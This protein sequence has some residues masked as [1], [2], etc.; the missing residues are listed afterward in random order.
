MNFRHFLVFLLACL[1]PPASI[2]TGEFL[3]VEAE[4]FL[5][6]QI[7]ICG[8]WSFVGMF[9]YTIKMPKKS[10]KNVEKAKKDPLTHSDKDVEEVKLKV[11][12]YVVDNHT[13]VNR[14]LS[15]TKNRKATIQTI[16]DENL[17]K[18]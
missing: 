1:I 10:T 5:A 14:L 11:F 18:K 15:D 13:F 6:L 3:Q 12:T 16:I 2:S 7:V 17:C 4:N 9:I 8:M